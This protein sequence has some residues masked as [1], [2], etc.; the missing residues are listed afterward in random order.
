VIQ[1]HALADDLVVV[2]ASVPG[3]VAAPPGA[4]R[5][6]FTFLLLKQELIWEKATADGTIRYLR[7]TGQW[8]LQGR[9]VAS[10][11]RG[12]SLNLVT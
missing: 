1:G 5:T 4:I 9:S 11:G 7:Q 2:E 10:S 8:S 6:P 3:A 12:A